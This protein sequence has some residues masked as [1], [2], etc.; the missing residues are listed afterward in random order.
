M[1]YAGS[2]ARSSIY[3][4]DCM[5]KYR[6]MQDTN[7]NSVVILIHLSVPYLEKTKGNIINISSIAALRS[8]SLF[9]IN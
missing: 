2:G 1:N 3:D 6:K 4:A 8:V 5:E 9:K 7:L